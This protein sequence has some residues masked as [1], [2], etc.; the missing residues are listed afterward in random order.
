[1]MSEMTRPRGFGR[2][3]AVAAVAAN[4]FLYAICVV[5]YASRHGHDEG[6]GA[7]IG[8]L[9]GG[10]TIAVAALTLILLRRT[11]PV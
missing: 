7:V 10:S 4:G 3:V 6:V 1:M 8:Y 11:T 2:A 5:A 9:I